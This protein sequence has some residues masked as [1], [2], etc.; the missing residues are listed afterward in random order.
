MLPYGYYTE[1][2]TNL[3]SRTISQVVAFLE[4]LGLDYDKGVDY[5]TVIYSDKDMV[6]ACTYEYFCN[7]EACAEAMHRLGVD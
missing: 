2:G 3:P 7:K 4:T 5:T 6:P 1:S